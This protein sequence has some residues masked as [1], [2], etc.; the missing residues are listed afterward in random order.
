MVA[1][2]GRDLHRVI[3][4]KGGLDQVRFHGLLEG[5]V[6]EPAH[7]VGQGRSLEPLRRHGSGRLLPAGEGVEIKAAGL[8]HQLMHR[9]PAPGGG[10]IDL[11]ALVGDGGAAADLLTHRGN[12][13]LGEVHHVGVIGVGL[14]DLHRGELGVMARA[15]ALVAEDPPQLI[16]PLK[17]ADHQPLEVEFGGDPQGEG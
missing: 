9:P 8:L 2:Q 1:G 7:R 4:H 14:I 6:E 12:Q 10:E 13:L 5:L 15:D 3:G 17:T 16:D 11:R